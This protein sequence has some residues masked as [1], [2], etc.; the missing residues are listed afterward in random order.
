MR[1]SWQ[2]FISHRSVLQLLSSLFL[3]SHFPSC[4]FLVL[5]SSCVYSLGFKVLFTRT[6]WLATLFQV[7][8]VPNYKNVSGLWVCCCSLKRE[9]S[10]LIL[11]YVFVL[12]TLLHR[13]QISAQ[14][15]VYLFKLRLPSQHHTF[16]ETEK[17]SGN[18]A[19][20]S[21]STSPPTYSCIAVSAVIF[22]PQFSLATPN[23]LI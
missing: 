22:M 9:M 19:R 18:N 21:S 8:C 2:L 16:Q 6:Q 5:W 15:C 20:N 7:L 17:L 4:F 12:F 23:S 3:N 13:V 11:F 14:A 1:G 10:F